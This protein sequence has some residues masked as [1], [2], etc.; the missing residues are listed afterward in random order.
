MKET[1]L[2]QAL[3]RILKRPIQLTIT[4]NT[5]VFLNAIYKKRV[6]GIRLHWM[7]LKAPKNLWRHIGRYIATHHKTS[8]KLVDRFIEDHWHWVR[9]PLPPIQT[10]GKTCDLEKIFRHLNR[11]YFRGKIKA[12]I[13]WGKSASRRAYEELQ[14]GSFSTSRQL[15]TIHP[16]LDQKWIPRFV[17]EATIFHEMCHAMIPVKTVNGRKQ[18]HPPAFKKLE[19]QYRHLKKVKTWEEK[20]INRLLRKP[21]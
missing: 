4:D 5:H 14:M 10:K 18:I 20:N 19:S 16:H 17:V 2:R 6:W 21:R 1:R 8:S 11:R 9:H 12:K 13:T 7:F 15:I 3:Q